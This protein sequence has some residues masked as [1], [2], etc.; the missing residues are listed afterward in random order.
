MKQDYTPIGCLVRFGI[1]LIAE[2]ITLWISLKV[3]NLDAGTS[4]WIFWGVLVIICILA[5]KYDPAKA[6]RRENAK[7]IIF[8]PD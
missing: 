2:F 6:I 5:Y 8:H 1:I 3:F 4:L 7:E